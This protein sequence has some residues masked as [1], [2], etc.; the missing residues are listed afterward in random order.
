M[1]IDQAKNLSHSFRLAADRNLE[2]RQLPNSQ[3]QMLAVPGVV[4]M[5]FS[6]ELGF[7]AMLLQAGGSPRGH[8]LS[9]LF[10][11]LLASKQATLVASVGANRSAFDSSLANAS[12]VFEEWRYIYEAQNASVD[13][14]F[15][16]SLADAVQREIL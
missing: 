14:A 9:K 11:S 13:M 12:R 7:K 10:S 5:A 4:C 2:Q 15:L 8:D 6:I 1:N 3:L 16:T